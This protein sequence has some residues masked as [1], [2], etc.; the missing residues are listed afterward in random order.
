MIPALRQWVD[1]RKRIEE[2]ELRAYLLGSSG[3]VFGDLPS[4][5]GKLSQLAV[6]RF[7]S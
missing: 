6:T 4:A 7:L 5:G 3:F 2:E 1:L